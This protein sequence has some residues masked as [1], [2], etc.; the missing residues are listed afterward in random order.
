MHD[1]A[2]LLGAADPAD[3][4]LLLRLEHAVADLLA[5]TS[6]G[7]DLYP[8][9]LEVI[10]SALAWP[11]G[12]VW[13]A[14][15][16]A[17]GVPPQLRCVAMWHAADVDVREFEEASRRLTLPSGV[18]LPGRVWQSGGP[19]WVRDAALDPDMPRAAIVGRIG[20]AAAFC[21]PI[22]SRDGIEALVEFF[23][24]TPLD[25][26][27]DLLNTMSS[28]G[29]R[30]GDALRRQRVDE[31]VRRSEGR[32]RAVI[33][34]ALDCVIIADAGGRVLEFNPAACRTFGYSRE[35][36]VGR[37]LADL[38]VPAALRARHRRGLSRY[39]RTGVARSLDQRLEIDG[40]R[41]DGTVF[42]VEL[43]ITR[44]PIAGPPVFAAYLRDL[45]ERRAVEGELR[46][47]R[48]RVVEAVVAERH[49][50]E[51]DLHDGA[52]QRL[53]S[54]GL[55]LARARGNLPTEP[56]RA[57]QVLDEAITALDEA[58]LELRA[59]ARGIHPASLTRYGLAAAVAD[60]AR[61]S[62]L[63]LQLASLPTRRF[64]M[65]IEATAYFV[66]SE[67][68]TNAARHAGTHRLTIAVDEMP[69]DRPAAL[70]VR[71]RDDGRGGAAPDRGT[72]L[73]G[74]A[75]RLALLDGTLDVSS[76]TGG[77]TTLVARIPL[78]AA[79]P[80]R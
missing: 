72:G 63:D 38:I 40:M 19:A 46:A 4:V 33:D 9:L 3:A 7:T 48:H 27:T 17:D 74:L 8:R 71:V 26:A 37:E 75:D 11:V 6:F 24:D 31:T 79:D 28:L 42:P 52:Q 77:G 20:L 12:A 70:V 18:G 1:N 23:T 29:R 47:S 41:A 67:A 62:P 64:P 78:P 44:V 16:H 65:A 5:E 14:S 13:A 69:P 2:E 68:L 30:I 59:L 43:T 76:P 56:E 80:P 25:P 66:V 34:S 36:T 57:A 60:L 39:L 32:L 53:V 10:G 73:R 51:R 21:F 58:A 45:T 54:L 15:E 49:R 50:L 61:R 35:E 22:A 55:M